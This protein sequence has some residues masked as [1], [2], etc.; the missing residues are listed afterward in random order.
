MWR[1]LKIGTFFDIG[2]YIHWSFLLLPLWVFIANWKTTGLEFAFYGVAVVVTV[3]ACVVLHEFGHA[4]TA[5]KFG[6]PTRDITLYPIGGVARLERMTERPTEELWIAIAGPAV[7]I[8]IAAILFPIAFLVGVK[9]LASVSISSF[10]G[11]VALYNLFLACFNMIPAFPMDGGRVLRA[12][13]AMGVGRLRATEIAANLGAGFAGVFFLGGIM[14]TMHEIN[15]VFL[16]LLSIFVML[17]GQQEL[18]AVRYRERMRQQEPLE[19]LPA[20]G[21][22]IDV[23][24]LPARPNF[25]GF[26]WDSRQGI[27]VEWRDGRPIHTISVQPE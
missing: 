3:F 19:V 13:L 22:V 26:T 12:L 15:G 25:S 9:D 16:M 8:V 5:R 4:L 23:G 18:M 24:A 27:W 7:N 11:I 10:L 20:D 14:L 6:I 1:S 21:D 2:L 17:M